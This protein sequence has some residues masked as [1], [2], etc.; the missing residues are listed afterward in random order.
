MIL[1]KEKQ[2]ALLKFGAVAALALFALWYFL[3]H[4]AQVRLSEKEKTSKDL[5]KKIAEKTAVV[6]RARE[7]ESQLGTRTRELRALEA[8]MVNGDI[9]LWIQKTLRDFEIPDQLEFTRYDPPQMVNPEPPFKGPYK[10]ASFSVNGT[11]TYHD[12]GTFLANFENSY[13]H[14]RIRRLEMEPS[15]VGPKSK[16]EKLNFFMELQALVSPANQAATRKSRS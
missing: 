15:S 16:D 14:I 5:A 7:I 8:Q 3:V 6:E 1:S 13:P 12:L 2:I 4:S 11:A 9:Y 10:V